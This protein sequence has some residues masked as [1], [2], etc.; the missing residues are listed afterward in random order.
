MFEEQP[1]KVHLYR[2]QG[3]RKQKRGLGKPVDNTMCASNH[4]DRGLLTTTEADK[5]TCKRC[6]KLMEE[7]PLATMQVMLNECA[8][9]LNK[10]EDQ[11]D[12]YRARIARLERTLAFA[13]DSLGDN[14]HAVVHIPT[15]LTIGQLINAVLAEKV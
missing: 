7:S 11:L 8:V 15:E 5:V 13:R 2:D 12:I 3:G 10:A 14:I 9:D 4:G 1:R 6:L